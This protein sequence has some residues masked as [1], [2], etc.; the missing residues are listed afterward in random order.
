MQKRNIRTLIA[1]SVMALLVLVL[2]LSA[3]AAAPAADIY[4]KNITATT[5]DVMPDHITTQVT[6]NCITGY[7]ANN[8]RPV[9]VTTNIYN[10]S[11]IINTAT[12]YFQGTNTATDQV[13]LKLAPGE[14]SFACRVSG[15]MRGDNKENNYKTFS[16]IVASP[17][18]VLV[19]INVAPPSSIVEIE[20]TQHFVAAGVDQYGKPY[21]LVATPIA[22]PIQWTV[23]AATPGTAGPIVGTID[24]TG[25]FTGKVVGKGIV[26]GTVGTIFGTVSGSADVSVVPSPCPW[27]GPDCVSDNSVDFTDISVTNANFATYLNGKIYN[28]DLS[29]TAALLQ[30]SKIWSNS[31]EYISQ[32]AIDLSE[33]L[34]S[35]SIVAITPDK[36]RVRILDSDQILRGEMFFDSPAP[37]PATGNIRVSNMYYCCSTV[38][39]PANPPGT[40]SNPGYAIPADFAGAAFDIINEGPTTVGP[41]TYIMKLDDNE[42]ARGVTESIPPGGSVHVQKISEQRFETL[43]QHQISVWVVPDNELNENDNLATVGVWV[44]SPPLPDFVVLS[45]S[46]S[47]SSLPP[48]GILTG[49]YVALS[50]DI[51]NIGSA[52]ADSVPLTVKSVTGETIFQEYE[53]LPAGEMKTVTYV[54]KLQ[55]PVMGT[56]LYVE[57]NAGRT[58]GETNYENNLLYVIVPPTP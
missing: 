16:L 51:G 54:T 4:V 1:P 56:E 11:Q 52:P 39:T 14:Y 23:N 49:D 26:V 17:P 19:S 38:P 44:Y 2:T 41:K 33:E 6:V 22:P 42:I 47:K 25:L 55:Y 30:V 57:L 48:G 21:S 13:I 20:K 10:G 34:T 36:F 32:E 15:N 3:S 7:S 27:G 28:K 58:I 18:P 46:A 9:I 40:P 53:N 24:S 29:R 50:C 12:H 5:G 31:E 8:N 43:G 37:V 35:F 45:C